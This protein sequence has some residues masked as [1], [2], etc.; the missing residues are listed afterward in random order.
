MI[1]M[2]GSSRGEKKYDYTRFFD[3]G[4]DISGRDRT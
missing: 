1:I 3:C 4:G 2:S